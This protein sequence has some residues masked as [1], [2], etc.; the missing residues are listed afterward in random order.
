[1]KLKVI[2]GSN[3]HREFDIEY[4]GLTPQNQIFKFYDFIEEI[5]LD[6]KEYV[7]I[8]TNNPYI[9]NVLNL[10]LIADR[11]PANLRHFTRGLSLK[12]EELEFY[13]LLGD[14]TLENLKAMNKNFVDTMYLSD[15]MNIIYNEYDKHKSFMK[16][17]NIKPFKE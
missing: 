4:A 8:Y 12:Y 16:R 17:N 5:F 2:I 1:M 13:R 14:D 15:V 3:E 7:E 10:L 11:V 6:K 9:V